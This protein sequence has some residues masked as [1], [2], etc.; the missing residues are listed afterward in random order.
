MIERLLTLIVDE[1][2]WLPVSMLLSSAAVVF[3]V[4][5]ARANGVCERQT[6]L[7]AMNLFFGVTI[8]VMCAGHFSAV[9]TRL[10]A[11]TLE[12]APARLYLIGTALALPSIAVVRHTRGL[13]TGEASARTTL[14][15]NSWLVLT[16]LALGPVNLPLAAPGLSTI[17]YQ[18]SSRRSIGWAI[19]SLA[20]VLNVS[21]FI[22]AMIFFA[23][24]Q[25]FE[26]FSGRE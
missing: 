21:L 26:Q 6:V 3:V 25:N 5:R 2:K 8:G 15:V 17:G 1:S 16:L 4:R 18:M 20:V 14:M 9:T 10:A 11:D 24:G 13:L 22:G 7:A 19:V 23:S 12:G